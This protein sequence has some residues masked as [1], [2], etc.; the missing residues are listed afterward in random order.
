MVDG[1]VCSLKAANKA[2]PTLLIKEKFDLKANEHT[3]HSFWKYPQLEGMKIFNEVQ[4]LTL[5]VMI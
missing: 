2:V 5:K 4:K 3:A 1:T